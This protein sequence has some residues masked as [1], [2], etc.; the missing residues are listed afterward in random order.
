MIKPILEKAKLAIADAQDLKAL[1][2]IRVTFLGKKGEL[3]A[4]LK[5]LG[6]LSK[7]ERPKMGEAINQAKTNVQTW[8]T[9]RKNHLETIELEKRLLE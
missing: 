5:S 4:L 9:D 7:E 3:T 6:T 2:E 8:L 1:D